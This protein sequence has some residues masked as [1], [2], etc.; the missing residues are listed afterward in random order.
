MDNFKLIAGVNRSPGPLRARDNSPIVLDGDT[1][2]LQLES[3]DE[4]GK[5]RRGR[6]GRELAGL[7]IN[8]DLHELNLSAP[9]VSSWVYISALV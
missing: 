6:E 2:A 4:I 5:R 7:P 8:D 3:I 1:I 9:L